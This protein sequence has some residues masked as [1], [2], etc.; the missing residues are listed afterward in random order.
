MNGL[1]YICRI[2]FNMVSTA[3]TNSKLANG[4][5]RWVNR[6]LQ[7]GRTDQPEPAVTQASRFDFP[8]D[9]S[10]TRPSRQARKSRVRVDEAELENQV[11][12]E[13]EIEAWRRHSLAP[14]SYRADVPTADGR[15]SRTS[16][17]ERRLDCP[18]GSKIGRASCRE[19]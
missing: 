9:Q 8:R 3:L 10:S 4:R 12:S 16:S 17:G 15:R 18:L 2:S 6:F 1:A 13:G 19:R 5:C 7:K 14:R 11:A